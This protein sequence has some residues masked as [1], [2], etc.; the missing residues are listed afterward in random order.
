M[1]QLSL[2]KIFYSVW[3]V[4]SKQIPIEL[5]ASEKSQMKSPEDEKI[6]TDV[7]YA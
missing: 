1:I 4:F 6:E 2:A 7:L 5:I 3:F